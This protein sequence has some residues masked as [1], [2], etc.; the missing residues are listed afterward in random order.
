MKTFYSL[1]L[2]MAMV[3]GIGCTKPAS[4]PNTEPKTLLSLQ[5]NSPIPSFPY[6]NISAS[7]DGKI[8]AV[9]VKEAPWAEKLRALGQRRGLKWHVVCTVVEDDS[10][11]N[12][13]AV[14]HYKSEPDSAIYVEDGAQP[15]WGASGRTQEEAGLKLIEKI[16]FHP[17]NQ[18]EHNPAYRHPNRQCKARVSGGDPHL[19]DQYAVEC[20]DCSKDKP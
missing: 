9:T 12:Y 3:G 11:F 6:S 10:P 20:K 5:G 13:F 14:A 17:P 8:S 16:E 2:T 19:P 1:L 18:P 7:P 15:W 4:K